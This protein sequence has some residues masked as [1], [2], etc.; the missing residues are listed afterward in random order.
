VVGFFERIEGHRRGKETAKTGG[1]MTRQINFLLGTKR[2][3]K[4]K[5]S[6]NGTGGG[7]RVLPGGGWGR[8]RSYELSGVRLLLSVKG[9]G[10]RKVR[11]GGGGRKLYSA[12]RS[13]QR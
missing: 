5:G 6:M 8:K 13:L 10:K 11:V 4:E 2:M 3:K 7:D 1:G 9:R 12:E